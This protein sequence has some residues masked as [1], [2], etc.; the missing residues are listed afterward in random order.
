MSK[1]RKELVMGNYFTS[2]NINGVSS[3]LSR[4][5]LVVVVLRVLYL[6][7]LIGVRKDELR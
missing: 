6:E 5:P 1:T 2:L 4:V 7:P 3:L